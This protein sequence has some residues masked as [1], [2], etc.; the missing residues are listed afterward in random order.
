MG[1]PTTTS[2]PATTCL[3]AC[4]GHPSHHLPWKP[5]L[6]LSQEL[7]LHSHMKLFK[8]LPF[9]PLIFLK[10]CDLIDNNLG[11]NDSNLSQNFI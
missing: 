4:M 2:L 8:N 5:C 9:L 10:Q 3:P 7:P 11:E 6:A 1:F